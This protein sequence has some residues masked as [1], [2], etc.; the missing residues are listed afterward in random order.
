MESKYNKENNNEEKK[1]SQL[2]EKNLGRV[3]QIIGP[4]LDVIF[5]PGKMPNIIMPW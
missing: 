2:D 3:A 1:V 4:V 5:P